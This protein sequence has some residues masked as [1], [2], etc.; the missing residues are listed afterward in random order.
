VPIIF[1]SVVLPPPEVPR[2]VMNSPWLIV[3]FTPR[4]AGTPSMP[5]R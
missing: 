5:R 2:I 4:R 1:N 3:R